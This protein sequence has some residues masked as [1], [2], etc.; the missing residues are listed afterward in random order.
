MLLQESKKGMGQTQVFERT[1]IYFS[2][3][4][5][6]LHLCCGGGAALSGEAALAAGVQQLWTF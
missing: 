2:S 5:Q 3:L 4:H 6:N 1:E